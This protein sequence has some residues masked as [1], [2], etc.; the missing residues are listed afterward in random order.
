MALNAERI[1]RQQAEI[2]QGGGNYWKPKEGRNVIRV[3]KFSHT[4]TKEDVKA[5]YFSRDE[6]GKSVEELCRPVT[7]QFGIAKG[8][9]ISTPETLARFEKLNRTEPEAAKK[10][11]PRQAYF[12]NIVDIDGKSMKVLPFGAAA[13]IYDK[14]VGYYID[15]DFGEEIFGAEGRDF[16]ITYD[17]KESPQ[18]MY[19]VILRDESKCTALP[20]SIEKEA[21]DFYSDEGYDLITGKSKAAAVDAEDEDVE[22]DEEEEDEDDLEDEEDSE[23]EDD[24]EDSEDEEDEEDDEEDED[25]EDEEKEEKRPRKLFEDDEDEDEEEDDLEYKEEKKDKK[26]KKKGKKK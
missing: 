3:L 16:V 9:V 13:S 24:A 6:L 25:D 20:S 12:M 7:R 17:P 2:K 23:D 26:K 19:K 4:V 1:R 18:K 15:P 10:I 5:G 22:D 11:A 14:I 8:P 21:I